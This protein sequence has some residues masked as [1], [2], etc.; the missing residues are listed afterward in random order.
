MV[1]SSKS[2][3][4]SAKANSCDADINDGSLL[5]Y[6]ASATAGEEV[7]EMHSTVIRSPRRYFD[8]IPSILGPESGRSINTK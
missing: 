8:L 5:M 2:V 6:Q 3:P 7:G 4:F 1:K